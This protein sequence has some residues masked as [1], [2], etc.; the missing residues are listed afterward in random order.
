MRVDNVI[1]TRFQQ[2]QRRKT[3]VI[4][5]TII[6]ATARLTATI[7][8]VI[9][10][11]LTMQVLSAQLLPFVDKITRTIHPPSSHPLLK[12][13]ML[14]LKCFLALTYPVLIFEIQSHV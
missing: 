8:G 2:G 10:L 3:R 11:Q 13:W 9:T 14:M 5:G 6:P 4:T 12:T 7:L 1:L